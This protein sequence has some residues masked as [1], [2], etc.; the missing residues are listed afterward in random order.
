[1]SEFTRAEQCAV[2][3][4]E[5]FRGDGEILVSAIGNL[6]TLGARLAKLSFEPDILMTDSV[7]SIVT[8]CQP[9]GGA[10]G[11]EP[12]VESWM[13]YRAIFELISSGRRHVMMGATQV[14]RFGN[15]NIACIGDFEKPKA[16]L[17]GMRGAPGN[18]INHT[19]SYWVP[20][21]SPK[22]FVEKVDVVSGLGYDRAAALGPVAS[23][24]HEIRRV[25]SNL[26]VVDFGG[27][28]HAMRLVS[29]HTGVSVDDVVAATGFE[30][31]IED[32]AETRA[33]TEAE[34][35]ILREQL[36]PNGVGSKEVKG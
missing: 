9:I 2:A 17:L 25:V 29:V 34:L 28:D 18:T 3:I 33:P 23:R 26:C 36:D 12:I 10:P 8:T 24:F 11:P 27:P 14:D 19:T 7:A 1:M 31:V 22:V 4:S 35:Q 20:N 16:Q 15:Q 5:C 32:V 30:L 13:P 6:P 21:H